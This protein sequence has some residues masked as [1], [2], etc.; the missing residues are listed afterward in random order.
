[1]SDQDKIICSCANLSEK[2]INNYFE[3]KNNNVPS[4]NQFLS[5]TK[6]GTYCT[7]CRLDLETIFIKKNIG[8]VNFQDVK[9]GKNLSIKKKFYSIIDKIFP[10]LTLRNQNFFPI[11]HIKNID[12]EQAIWITNMEIISEKL[13][14]KIKID[15]VEVTINL[16]NSV[17]KKVWTT[18]NIVKVN[19]RGIFNIPSDK[20]LDKEKDISI[21]WIEVLR[22][23]KINCS[24]GTTRPQIMVYSQ[25]SNCSVHGQDIGHTEGSSHSSIFRPNIDV[26]ILSFINPSKKNIELNLEPPLEINEKFENKNSNFLKIQLPPKGSKIHVINQDDRFKSFDG[27]YF[28]IS[29]KGSG[30]YKSHVYCVSKNFKFVSLDHL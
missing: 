20:I 30:K 9:F 19:N 1:M 7:A 4:F 5:E 10:K 12:F 8:D 26:Q 22:K 11:L 24:K 28:S 29:W 3:S 16:Y 13:K 2:K 14:T 6:A 27:K 18:K 21:G 17:G 23:F 25:N 15:D